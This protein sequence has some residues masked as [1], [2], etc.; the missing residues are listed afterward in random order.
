MKALSAKDLRTFLLGFI[1]IVHNWLVDDKVMGIGEESV[2][3]REG[4]VI[5]FNMFAISR[6]IMRQRTMLSFAGICM[7]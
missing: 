5:C 2:F 3:V 6:C 7:C 1:D 4:W